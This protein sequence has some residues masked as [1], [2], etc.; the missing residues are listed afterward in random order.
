MKIWFLPSYKNEAPSSQMRVYRIASNLTCDSEIIP[1][2]LSVQEKHKILAN[3]SDED[4]VIVQKWRNDFNQAIHIKEIRGK[5]IFDIDDI[6]EDKEVL[7]LG[8]VCDIIFAANHYLYDWAKTKFNKETYLIP[9][10]IDIPENLQPY[11]QHERKNIVIAKYGVDRYIA[12]IAKIDIWKQLFEKY[13]I[14]M[15]ILG[16]TA[17]TCKEQAQNSIGGFCKTYPLVPLSSFWNR[18]GKIVSTAAFGIMPL[19]RSA[20]GKSAFSVLTMMA[21]G[22]PVIAS[23]YGECDHIISNGVNGYIAKTREEWLSACE[24]I[25]TNNYH[26]QSLSIEATKTIVR[27]YTIEKITKKIESSLGIK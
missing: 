23:P 18:Y 11:S 10:G 9:T 13:N 7:E 26:R 27:T 3:V 25:I 21:A 5:K 22:L 14:A 4:F 6:C 17:N 20:Q 16:T 24:N 19:S 1:Y 12:P 2:N 15:R 8:A